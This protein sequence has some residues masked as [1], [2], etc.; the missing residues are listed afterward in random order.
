MTPGR[1]DLISMGCSK[2]L[3]DSER[4]SRR[5]SVKGY[6]LVPD[7]EEPSGEYAIVNTCGF[8]GDAKEES[9]NIILGLAELKA[10]ERI[11]KL[12][13]MGCLSER[14]RDELRCEIPE[15]D[16]I[17]GKYD[18]N[19]ITE[20]LPDRTGSCVESPTTTADPKPWERNL[21][22]PPYSAYMKVS[23]GCD[24]MCAYC[25]IPLITGRHKS[26]P[27]KEILE[28]TRELVSQGVVEFNIIAQDLSAYG[29]DLPGSRSRLAELIDAM[30]RIDGV[31]WIRLHYAYPVDFP[32]DVL[33]VMRQR[34]NV[35][36]YLDVALQHVSTPVLDNMRRHI[37]REGTLDFIARLRREVPG[38]RIRTTLMV[39][40][41]GEGEKEFKELLD[42]VHM[43]KFDRMGAFAYSEED[44]TWAARHLTDDIPP[45]IKQHRLDELMAAQ[46][47]VAATVAD[48]FIGQTV[49][50]LVESYQGRRAVGR[51]QWD[52]PEVDPEDYVDIP[53]NVSLPPVGSFIKAEITDAAPFELYGRLVSVK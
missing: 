12:I 25:A 28:E 49:D 26:R 33:E 30:S 40:F 35:C 11:G 45:E 15:I 42:F 36:K 21:T 38:I 7:P 2:N 14:Y 50:V 51:T 8:I 39:G 27:L 17:F 23:E 53:L 34:P 19:Q 37:D 43:A 47:E 10:E 31:R 29:T 44:D 24:R 52:S 32:W 46:E 3:V 22:T 48:S 5:L 9:V 41:P 1:I 16:M 20:L 13:V 6:A 18:W 4:L